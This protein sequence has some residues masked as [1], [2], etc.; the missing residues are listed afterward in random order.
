MRRQ[1]AVRHR[2]DERIHHQN[3]RVRRLGE[4]SGN[5][6]R[7]QRE[8]FHQ[9]LHSHMREIAP[10]AVTFFEIID[11]V[12]I[13]MDP[14]TPD[15]I[16]E[17]LTAWSQGDDPAALEHLVPLVEAELRRIAR[18]YLNKEQ[19]DPLLQTTVIINEVF[20]RLLGG[21][22]LS[23]QSRT[24]FYALCAQIMRRILVDHA[25]ARKTAKRGAGAAEVPLE[26]SSPLAREL[27]TD[28]IA[29]DQALDALAQQDARKSKVVELRFFGG[30]SV[31]ETTEALHISEDSV[32]RDWKLAK[33]WLLRE[34]KPA[35]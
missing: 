20:L 19:R 10:A 14:A 5:N 4:S 32:V 1:P 6:E 7:K 3:H 28:I 34:L 13:P 31:E 23:C 9:D 16:T 22:P 27:T 30:L 21:K 29:I 12:E 33:L 8:C 2:A 25:R 15:R 26:E 24:H 18:S 35:K 17:M 11:S